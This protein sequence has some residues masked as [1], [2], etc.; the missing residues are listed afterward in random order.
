MD[1]RTSGKA[2]R[3]LPKRPRNMTMKRKSKRAPRPPEG[4]I[5]KAALA[6]LYF[7]SRS[8]DTSLRYLRR[9]I[10]DDPFLRQQLGG[11]GQRKHVHYYTPRQAAVLREFF[12]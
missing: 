6:M 10:H 11:R 2:A 8:A 4:R 1:V 9:A 3:A 12:G 5:G 7:P